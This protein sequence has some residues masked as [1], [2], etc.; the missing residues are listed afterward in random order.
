[1]AN[2]I[3]EVEAVRHTI[4]DATDWN[5]GHGFGA[6]TDQIDLTSLADGAARQSAKVDLAVSGS[7]LATRYDVDVAIEWDVAPADDTSLDV[8]VGFSHIVTAATGNPGGLSGSDAAYTGTTNGTLA[9]GLLQLIHIG[10]MHPQNEAATTVNIQPI[11][12][13]IA[14]GQWAIFVVVN[15][16]GQALEGDAIEMAIRVSGKAPEVQ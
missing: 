2:R 16:G 1:M 9:E 8:Y 15:D 13:F 12:S 11:G 4:A 5:D 10:R 3:Y 6:D 14:E 7:L